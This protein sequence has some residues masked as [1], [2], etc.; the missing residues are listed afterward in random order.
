MKVTAERIQNTAAPRRTAGAGAAPRDAAFA[1]LVEADISAGQGREAAGVRAA[2]A[3]DSLI[4]AQEVSE[5][6]VGRR[7]AV[8]RGRDLLD[9]LDAVRVALIAGA[10]PKQRLEQLVATLAAKHTSLADPG[11][12]AVLDEIELRARVELAKFDTRR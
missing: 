8:E 2:T 11:L 6:A 5:F 7:R 3:I 9:Q 4:S 12:A 1:G 10:I